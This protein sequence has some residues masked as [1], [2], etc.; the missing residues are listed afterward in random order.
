[1]LKDIVVLSKMKFPYQVSNVVNTHL[2]TKFM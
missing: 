1:M 2:F